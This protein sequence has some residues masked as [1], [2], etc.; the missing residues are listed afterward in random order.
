MAKA[1][2][3]KRDEPSGSDDEEQIV[4]PKKSKVDSLD[5]TSTEDQGSFNGKEWVWDLDDDM[6]LTVSKFKGKTYVDVRHLWDGKPTKK[7]AHLSVE[8][9]KKIA[10][11]SKLD[12]A[13]SKL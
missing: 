5:S 9:F 2:A 3:V 7:G 8:T 4:E 10:N 12:E 6:R 13:L 11:F 1:K